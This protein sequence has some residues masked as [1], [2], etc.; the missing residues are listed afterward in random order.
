MARKKGNHLDRSILTAAMQIL[1]RYLL[2]DKYRPYA[3]VEGLCRP[4]GVPEPAVPCIAHKVGLWASAKR[5]EPKIAN[6]ANDGNG[7]P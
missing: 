7:R 6:N 5:L 3:K 2:Y 4:G 1:A